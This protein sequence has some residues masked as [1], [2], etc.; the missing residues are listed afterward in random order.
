MAWFS[1]VFAVDF[2]SAGLHRLGRG[3]DQTGN[4]KSYPENKSLTD[5]FDDVKLGDI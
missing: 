1:A 4:L 2:F 3:W 5:L